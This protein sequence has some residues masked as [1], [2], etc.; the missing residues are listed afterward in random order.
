MTSVS[1]DISKYMGNAVSLASIWGN[2]LINVKASPYFAKGDGVTDDTLAIR[3]ACNY[4]MDQGGGEIYFPGGTYNV[5]FDVTDTMY[6]A[7]FKF[8]GNTGFKMA[9]GAKIKVVGSKP[10]LYSSVFGVNE[11]LLPIDNIQFSNVNIEGIS[12]LPVGLPGSDQN[13]IGISFAVSPD[14]PARSIQNVIIEN[15][16]LTNLD[17]GIYIVHRSTVGSTTRQTQNVKIK[18]CSAIGCVGSFATLDGEDIIV[19]ENTADGADTSLA[20]D[21]ISIHAGLN[22]KIQGNE[23]WNYGQGQV[24]N[25]RNS[26]ENLCGSKNISLADNTIRDCPT[27]GIQ[28]SLQA[29]ESV[30]GVDNVLISDNKLANVTT[31]IVVTPGAAS[32]G[33]PLRFMKVEGNQINAT[34]TGMQVNGNAGIPVEQS[35]ISN[36]RITSSATTTGYGMFLNFVL[37]SKITGNDI[38]STANAAGHKTFSGSNLSYD[39]IVNNKIWPNTDSVEVMT[40]TT[41]VES[42]FS[43]NYV[44][45]VYSFTGISASLLRSNLFQSLGTNEG[46][47]FGEGWEQDEFNNIVIYMGA[48]PV[49]LA[50]LKGDRVINNNPAPSGYVGFI[51]TTSGT[52]GTWKG[53]GAIQA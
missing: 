37:Y 4:V 35:D 23:F 19:E 1:T 31:G 9:K 28:I 18:G 33:T 39:Q 43:S 53:F 48:A 52:P 50:W 2:I 46:R 36:N 38:Q 44:R 32:A 49:S 42:N 27:I 40:I 30:F 34:L 45:G 14:T 10:K 6:Y 11:S 29:G 7:L 13:P 25:V 3:S 15:C 16:N 8:G 51:C 5:S 26:P 20:F 17:Y 22:V 41:L 24:I 12:L 21:A 47:T